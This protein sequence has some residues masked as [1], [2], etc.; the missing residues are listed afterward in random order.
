[1]GLPPLRRE[2]MRLHLGL[3]LALLSLFAI[4]L[5]GCSDNDNIVVTTPEVVV[6]PEEPP[7]N[8]RNA[9]ATPGDSEVIAGT[10]YQHTLF[11]SAEGKCQHCHNDLYDTWTQSGHSEAWKGGIFQ[12]QFQGVIRARINQLDLSN[13]DNLKKFKGRVSFCVKCHAPAAYYSGDI[14]IDIEKL[15]DDPSTFGMLKAANE[16]NLAGKDF[17]ISQPTSVVWFDALGKVF[18]STLH[19]GN[20]HNREGVNCSY[21]HSI[22]TVRMLNADVNDEGGDGGQ[23]TLAKPLPGTSLVAGSTLDYSADGENPHMN[24][25]FRFAAAEIY[26]DYANTPKTTAEFDQNKKSD[27]R[28]TIKSIVIGQHTGGPFYGPFGVTGTKNRH[29]DDTVDRLALVKP[30][31]TE[32]NSVDKHFNAQSKGLCLSC[33]QCAMGTKNKD[34]GKFNT[35][36]VVWQANSGFAEETNHTDTEYSPKCAKCHMERVANKTVLHKWNSPDE[37]FTKEDGVTKH[38]DPDSGIG[39]VAEKYLNNHAFMA[40]KTKNY[41]SVKLAS[42]IEGGLS[43]SRNG[44]DVEVDASILN[45]AGHLFPGT[46]PMRRALL[47]VIATDSEGTKLN[48][49]S[50]TGMSEFV[51]VSH[52]VATLP[53]ESVVEDSQVVFRKAPLEP[54]SFTGQQPDLDGSTV[55][56]QQF[57]KA[58]IDWTS[59]HPG[60]MV[61]AKPTKQ[62]NDTWR[63]QGKARIRAIVD[64]ETTDHFT[65]IY[66]YQLGKQLDDGTF[67][68]RPGIDSNNVVA[69]S[70]SPNEKENY[71]IVFDAKDAVGEVTVAYR[72]YYMTKGANAQFP[73]ADDGFLNDTVNKDKK[74]LI[75]EIFSESTAVN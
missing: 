19:V 63:F 57:S 29:P 66:G 46:M 69:T 5:I 55:A 49:K 21:C 60:G 11:D 30:S 41:G 75:S 8:P 50:A 33:H 28:H 62:A 53:G 56:S 7:A 51:D 71:S 52:T 32:E 12:G 40:T 45:L 64:A 3:R 1:M 31:F 67:V 74:F 48:L 25:F 43:A 15:A 24:Q 13:P 26:E 65:R 54:I 2:K 42:A 44:D 17:D 14:K 10:G 72:V 22:E 38:F 18:K 39:P 73:T 47:R 70:M 35:G 36:C 61:D 6:T 27:G 58:S 23:Y 16:T 9:A 4:S 68:I 20:K 34:T 37:L 59:V